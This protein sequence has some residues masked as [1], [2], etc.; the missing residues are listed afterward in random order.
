MST[1]LK[2]V[3]LNK[4]E[5]EATIVMSLD[6]DPKPSKTRIDA[7]GNQ[8]GGSNLIVCSTRGIVRTG[9]QIK[10]KELKLSINGMIEKD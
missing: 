7:N 1:S 5:T 8:K 6:S 4:D 2:S 10:G 9:V 3:K